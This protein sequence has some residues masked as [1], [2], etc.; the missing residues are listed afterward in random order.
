[1]SCLLISSAPPFH[2]RRKKD[3]KGKC[4][5]YESLHINCV[6]DLHVYL[7]IQIVKWNILYKSSNEISYT[8]SQMKYSVQ[9]LKL[10]ILYKFSNEISYIILQMKYL[11]QILKWNIL[12]K[13][14][15]EIS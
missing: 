4:T 6:I 14:S 12:D 11:L 13:S 15:N 8:N 2:F 9:I 3:G 7:L 1:M 10:K 5:S